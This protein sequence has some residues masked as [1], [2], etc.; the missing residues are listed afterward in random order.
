MKVRTGLH[1]NSL[2]F[3]SNAFLVVTPTPT[4][5]DGKNLRRMALWGPERVFLDDIPDEDL[6]QAYSDAVM[7]SLSGRR[8]DPDAG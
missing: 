2:I 7:E 4:P 5:S 8:E 3:P 1:N 6:A